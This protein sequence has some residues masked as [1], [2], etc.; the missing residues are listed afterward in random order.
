MNG[1]SLGVAALA[2]TV[3]MWGMSGVAIKAVSSTG[4]VT[5][6]YRL[7]F[8]IPALWLVMLWPRLGP[9]LDRRWLQASLVGGVLFGVHQILYFTS[10]KLTSVVNVSL[11]GALQPALVLLLAGRLFGERVTARAVAWSIV[12][13]AGTMVVVLG[14]A[15]AP[16]W[17][18]RGDVLAWINLFAF[19]A[20]FLASK[21]F[22]RDVG[23]WEYVIGMTTVAGF[24]MLTANLVTGQDLST[25]H[26]R[27]WLL[28]VAIAI[29]PGTLGH[30]LSNWA[31]AHVTAF[32]SSMILLAVPV[33]ATAGAYVF[34]DERFTL[35]QAVGGAVVLFAIAMLV[36][37]TS[38]AT[39]TA[40]AESAAETDAP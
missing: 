5:A 31:H 21:R 18:L 6:L 17:S 15:H 22:R 38:G 1:Q 12:A 16:S 28:L 11:I 19:T 32:V 37:S 3:I 9:R 20:Y 35:V 33:V 24:V 26:G 34:L 7:W 2:L 25:P 29:F 14:S 4:L 10:L 13:L 40:L 39:A 27:D 36:S 23:A 30:V 8:A